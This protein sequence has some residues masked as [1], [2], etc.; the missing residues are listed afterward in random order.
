VDW[1]VKC[2]LSGSLN[3]QFNGP[4]GLVGVCTACATWLGSAVTGDVTIT[5]VPAPVGGVAEQP[6][7]ATLPSASGRDHG[8]YILGGAVVLLIAAGAAGWRKRR[9]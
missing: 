5:L 1:T 4:A 6:D 3:I 2:A 8:P 9:S 7:V